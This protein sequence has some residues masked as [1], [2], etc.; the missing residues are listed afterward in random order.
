[1]VLENNSSFEL[2]FTLLLDFASLDRN[3]KLQTEI[4]DIIKI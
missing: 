3:N 2:F 1:M 4:R